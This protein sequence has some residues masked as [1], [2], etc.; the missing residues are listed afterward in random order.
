[1]K[2]LNKLCA[3]LLSVAMV[4]SC[5][6]LPAAATEVGVSEETVA[7]SAD[8]GETTEAENS[9][10]GS[11]EEEAADAEEAESASEEA[12]DEEEAAASAEEAEEAAAESE[13]APEADEPADEANVSIVA[14]EAEDEED[15]DGSAE[16]EDEAADDSANE[17]EEFA[18]TAQPADVYAVADSTATVSFTVVATGSDL[19]YQWQYLSSGATTWH[20]CTPVTSTGCYTDTVSLKALV[21]RD[22][23]QYRC[24]VTNGDGETLTSDAATLS[25]FGIVT[26]PEDVYTVADSTAYVS[27][28]VEAV[29]NDLTY[30]WQYLED[31]AT[32]WHNCTPVTSTGCY[33]D[34]VSVK[35]LA[36]RDGHQYRCMVTDEDGNVAYSDAAT[37]TIVSETITI[38]TQPEDVTTLAYG[39]VTFTVE[40]TGV[41]LTYQWQYQTNSTTWYDCGSSDG[42][43]CDTASY[44]L[45]PYVVKTTRDGWKY[46]CVITDAYGNVVYSDAATLNVISEAITITAQPEDI[47]AVAD[48][49]ATV[50]FTVAATSN[51]GG[52]LTYQWQYLNDGATIWHDCTPVT[53]T[54][55]YTETVSLK[56]LVTRDG[57]SYRCV[58]TDSYGNTVTSDAATISMFGI[59]TQPED[60]Y[61]VAD[62][63][64]TISF[65]VEAVGSD[66]T[67]QW[68]Y[69]TATSSKWYNCTA[70]TGTGCY[71]DTVS[72][73]AIASRDGSQYR[74]VITNS[75]GNTVTSDAAA[76]SMFGIV[77]DP[78]NDYSIVGGTVS[79]TVEAVGSDL[80]YQWQYQTT[81][82]TKWY[83]CTATTSEGYATDAITLT[84]TKG[85]NGYKYRCMVT[86]AYGNVAYS[87]EAT[88]TIVSEALT[89]V[90]Q[91]EDVTAIAYGTATFTV[92]A[93]GVDLTYQWQYQT[94]STT[95]YDCTSYDS[96]DYNSASYTLDPYTVKTTRDGWK[97][98]C[99]ITDAYGDVVYSDAAT[100]TVVS[101]L[102]ILTQPVDVYSVAGGTS[103]FTVEAVG[104]D[105]TYQWQYLDTDHTTTNWYDCTP[106]TSTGCYTD[107]LTVKSLV[108]RNEHQYHCV[109][110]DADGNTVTTDAAELYIFGIVT[111]PEDVS[112]AV[113]STATFTVEAV[114]SDLTYQWQYQTA[115][116]SK[117]YSCTATTGEG[118]ASASITLTANKGRSGYKYRCVI[119]DAYGNT[120]TSEQAVL[121]VTTTVAED[122]ITITTQPEDV[123]AVKGG[124]VTL[125]VEATSNLDEELTYQWQYMTA[126]G[127]K[128]YNCTATTGE[129]YASA[130]ITLTANKGR[131]GYSY[132]CIIT[133]E[134]GNVVYTDAITLTVTE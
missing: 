19:T 112:A 50:S 92:E 9:E 24:V 98:R 93:T 76:V 105:L 111:Q 85:R 132:R 122:A 128:W 36:T 133:D 8:T 69:M 1:M 33:T 129:G 94:N 37:L 110:T 29:G 16:E 124:S 60:V 15:A 18:I 68:Q 81:N 11:D 66:L 71:T 5:A 70:V 56:A 113:G 84:A 28:T 64:A 20:N 38:V 26:D 49:T 2:K 3:L 65:T 62:S 55:C 14:A 131:N 6:S 32:T 59:V 4:L 72:V 7:A 134:S 77:T 22:G 40:A 102:T 80:T 103:T 47:Y 34:T 13:A 27:F 109:I 74:C 90:T 127:S 53:S 44:T 89:I 30:Q 117:W 126:T 114:G 63:T 58:I 116:G 39:D 42:E 75:Y 17:T 35:A 10:E 31:D 88:L 106:V 12:A 83:N 43:G 101:E 87:D 119:T 45:D 125:T 120:V 51:L 115:S 41:D 130:S 48:S 95:W 91:P 97:Y 96:E 104:N 73:K 82:G 79:F 46:R 25:M 118:Y 52:E 54:G 57:H 123:S 108:G 107:T 99:M 23:S 121:T 86:D 67:Y 61:A 78:E 100:L 21:T